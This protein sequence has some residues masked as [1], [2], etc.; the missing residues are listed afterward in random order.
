MKEN[1][2]HQEKYKDFDIEIYTDMD[3]ESPRDWDNLG[4]MA[5]Y[6]NRYRLGDYKNNSMCIQE[7]NDHVKRKDIISLPLYLYDHSGI[8]MRTSPFSDPWDSGQVG[9]IWVSY[10]NIR[11][12][13]GVKHV[14][15][16]LIEK[17]KEILES[18]VKV[19][20]DYIMGNVYGYVVKRNGVEI[21]SCWGF[22]GDWDGKEHGALVAAKEFVDGYNS[23][24]CFIEEGI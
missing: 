12:N 13:F 15:K 19:Y 4:T 8:T 5:C 6:H 16:R 11:K 14:T 18:E 24:K 2:V 23:S 21:D 7:I 1:L 10:E 20:N 9:Y 17:T 22:I 3:P